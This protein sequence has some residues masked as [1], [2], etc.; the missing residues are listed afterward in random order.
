MLCP[1]GFALP[2]RRSGAESVDENSGGALFQRIPGYFRTYHNRLLSA[3][4]QAA[5][6]RPDA[7]DVRRKRKHDDASRSLPAKWGVVE[8]T[9]GRGIFVSENIEALN[10]IHVDPRL[11]ASHIRR[12]LDCLELISLTV[13][14]VACHVAAHVFPEHIRELIHR[15]DEVKISGSLYQPAPVILLEFLTEHIPY[16][17]L[18]TIYTIILKN[19][20]IGRKIPKLINGG[21]RPN[22]SEIHRRCAEAADTLLGGDQSAFAKQAAEMFEY[23]HQLIVKECKRLGYWNTVQDLYDGSQLWK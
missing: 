7:E 14:G 19:Y 5:F 4:R 6:S 3:G 9:R 17:A 10:N 22:K 8:A 13:E 15:L 2:R 16:E 20:R 21:N 11:I 23:T 1:R 12:Y 18:K